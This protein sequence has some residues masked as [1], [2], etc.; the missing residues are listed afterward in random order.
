MEKLTGENISIE[1]KTEQLHPDSLAR[2]MT[3]FSNTYGGTIYVSVNDDG[4]VSGLTLE[5]KWD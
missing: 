4:S 5:R 3:A 2:E 1:Y